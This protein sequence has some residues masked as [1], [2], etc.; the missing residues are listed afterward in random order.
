MNIAA[1]LMAVAACLA[2]LLAHAGAA[3]LRIGF[4]A[5]LTSA[6]PHVLNGANRNILAHVY[7]SLVAQDDRLRP[8]PSLATSWRMV[9]P[10]SWEFTLRPQ[11]R[12]H[13]GA[14]LEAQDVKY[15]IE[16]AIAMP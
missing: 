11:V 4:K 12:F 10:T 6:D 3:E 1:R 7:E 15:S 14:P 5:E 16:R 2:G 9:T 13:N 8:L